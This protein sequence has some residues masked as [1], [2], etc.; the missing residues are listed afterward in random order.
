MPTRV[1]VDIGGTFTD[2]VHLDEETGAV[3]LA[4]AATTPRAFEEGVL[5]AVGQTEL[6]D[7]ASS[8]TARPS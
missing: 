5:D 3:G 4:K 8:R 2:L 1:A 7:V 6:D